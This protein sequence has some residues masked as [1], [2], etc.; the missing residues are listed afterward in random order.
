LAHKTIQY[1]TQ[2]KKLT[3]ERLKTGLLMR[4]DPEEDINSLAK[5]WIINT[6]TTEQPWDN[7]DLKFRNPLGVGKSRISELVVNA[8]VYKTTC[9][10]IYRILKRAKRITW[11][12][13][14]YR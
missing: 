5:N 3:A 13:L 7:K 10:G 11:C 1:I 9:M 12:W 8:M 6:G 2:S 14:P 4:F